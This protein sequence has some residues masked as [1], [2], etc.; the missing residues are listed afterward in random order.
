M[1]FSVSNGIATI[2]SPT[3]S[4]RS[5]IGTDYTIGNSNTYMHKFYLLVKA[6][7]PSAAYS[8]GF[9]MSHMGGSVFTAPKITYEEGQYTKSS[10]IVIPSNYVSATDFY[11]GIY[12]QLETQ[13]QETLYID[14]ILI[15]DLTATFGSGNEPDKE[16]CDNHINYFDGT[17]TIYK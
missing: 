12:H 7:A 3:E 5:L 16:W 11:F 2:I 1:T 6:K 14:Y 13:S 10:G 9:G 15:I 4:W 17:I 8:F